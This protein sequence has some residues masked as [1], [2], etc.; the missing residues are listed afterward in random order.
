MKVLALTGSPRKGGNTEA[1][2][3]MIAQGVVS[4]G[5]EIE[6]VRITDHVIGPCIGC[7]GC[8]KTGRC[9]INDDMQAL[10]SR[11][12]AVHSIIIASPV[13]FYA[14]SAQTKIFIDRL[15]ALWSRKQL[16]VKSGS[17]APDPT[18]KGYLVSVA[19]TKGGKLFVGSQLCAEYAFDAMG[20]SYGGDFLVRGADQRG[21][22]KEMDAK[23]KEAELF[24]EALCLGTI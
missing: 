8:T 2:V 14:L 4:A 23:M 20:F 6:T 7:G 13:Y 10:Y 16:L 22:V 18:R 19:A 1:L 21:A 9:V 17:W 5:G 12:D 3:G 24:G 15:Q 11:I